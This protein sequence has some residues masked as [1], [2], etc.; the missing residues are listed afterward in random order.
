[1]PMITGFFMAW[2]MFL[3]IPCPVRR[4]DETARPYML[5]ELPLV[6]LIVG[7]LWAAASLICRRL[8]LPVAALLLTAAPWLAT[9]CIHLDGYMDVCDAALS[10][11]DLAGRRRILKDSHSGAFAVIGM[12]L[13]ALG[14]WSFFLTGRATWGALLLIPVATRACAGL[15]V[16]LLR[17]MDRSQYSGMAARRGGFAAALAVELLAAVALP[18]VLWGSFAPMAAAGVYW[19]CAFWGVKQ[20]DGMNGD[21]SGFALTLGELAGVAVMTCVR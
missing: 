21:I 13:L 16:L 3:A 20:L 8:P 6:G 4:W 10:R 9:G 14:Q 1:M 5:A 11:R 12:V 2:G 19:L 15:A 17:P 7:G 18:L